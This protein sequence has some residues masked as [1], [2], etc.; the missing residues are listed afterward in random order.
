MEIPDVTAFSL[1]DAKEILEKA[2]MKIETVI[3]AAPPRETG[4]ETGPDFRVLTVKHIDSNKV[5]LIVCKPL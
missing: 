2:G 5:E 4:I 3:V 1:A